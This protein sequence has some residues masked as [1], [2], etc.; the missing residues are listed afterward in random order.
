M[1]GSPGSHELM[2]LLTYSSVQ[3]LLSAGHGHSST[4]AGAGRRAEGSKIPA[5]KAVPRAG[6]S[7]GRCGSS[8]G[9]RR[10]AGGPEGVRSASWGRQDHGPPAPPLRSPGTISSTFLPWPRCHASAPQ[11]VQGPPLPL[12][13]WV[14]TPPDDCCSFL[15]SHLPSPL[16]HPVPPG[17]GPSPSPA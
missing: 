12:L 13:S 8:L 6:V 2:H 4:R 9:P 3:Y 5:G 11:S 17:V 14:H 16:P 1:S 10:S 7:D 15:P